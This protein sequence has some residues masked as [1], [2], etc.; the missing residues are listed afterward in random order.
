MLQRFVSPHIG[1][2]CPCLRSKVRLFRCADCDTNQMMCSSCLVDSHKNC[3]FH[4]AEKWNG[5]FFERVEMSHLGLRVYLGHDGDRCP[6]A[7]DASAVPL[8]VVDINGIHRSS[9]VYCQCGFPNSRHL[10]LAKAG[11][12]PATVRKPELAFTFRCLSDF[13]V[14]THTSRKS[15]FDYTKAMGRKTN[16]GTQTAVRLLMLWQTIMH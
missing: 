16:D 7:S 11:L 4:W 1:E 12:F 15:A 8:T 3:L 6:R 14:H 5:R 10:Q 9:A 13:H 2:P